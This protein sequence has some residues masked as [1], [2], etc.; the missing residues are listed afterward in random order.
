MSLNAPELKKCKSE[1]CVAMIVQVNTLKRLNI[2]NDFNIAYS[3]S[4]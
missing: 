4:N 2:M 3:M 1:H